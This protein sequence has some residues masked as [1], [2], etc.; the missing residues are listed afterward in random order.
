MAPVTVSLILLILCCAGALAD[1]NG[2][3]PPEKPGEC[4]PSLLIAC[5]EP[6]D[7][8]CKSDKECLGKQKCCFFKCNKECKDP[9]K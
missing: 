5:V 4:P 6:V 2:K 1:T 3:P 8:L 7:D 9:I